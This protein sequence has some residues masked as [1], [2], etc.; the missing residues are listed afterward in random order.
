MMVGGILVILDDVVQIFLG[1]LNP[2]FPVVLAV[3]LAVI[4]T[5]WYVG[6]FWASAGFHVL[7]I[8]TAFMKIFTPR[9]FKKI[10]GIYK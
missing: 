10:A 7:G 4:F 1:I 9:K 6:V 8:P 2:L 3:V 5:P